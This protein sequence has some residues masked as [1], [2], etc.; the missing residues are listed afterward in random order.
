MKIL[1][2][3]QLSGGQTS[4]MRMRAFERLGHTVHGVDTMEPWTRTSWLKRQAQRRLECGPVVDEV[5]RSV[6]EAARAFRPDLLW[7]EKQEFLRAETLAEMRNLGARLVH[8]TPDPYFTLAWKRTR[9]MDDSIR[10]FDVLVYS[11]SYERCD[12]EA[13][14]RPLIYVP[15]GYCDEVHRPLASDDQRWSCSVASLGGWEPHRQLLL[16]A[17]AASGV[18]V[19]IW[20]FHWEFLCDGRWTPRRH[21]IL[22]QEAGPARFSFQY[23]EVIARA[24]QGG[25]VYG[26]DYARALTGARIGIGFLRR[27]CPE[28]HTSRSFEIPACGSMLLA[29]RT[30]E[31]Q[32]FFIEG[33]EAEF[34]ASE[35]E[36]LHKIRFYR[37]NEASRRRIAESGYKRCVDG[38]YAYVHRLRAVLD[39]MQRI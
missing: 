15:L 14:A 22:R 17:I 16:H 3:G 20:G 18:D 12:Y 32:Q 27:V 8:F 36:L 28:Q 13:L 21:V 23:D 25:E 7:A 1:F 9:L 19:K 31:H 38:Q 37:A 24:Y 10:A 39:G 2:A 5:N 4:L 6:L 35:E 26:D 29:E 33:K 34:F 30:N 11:K